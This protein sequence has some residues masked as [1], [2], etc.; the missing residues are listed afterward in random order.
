LEYPGHLSN[1]RSTETT[2]RKINKM[3]IK[4]STKFAIAVMFLFLYKEYSETQF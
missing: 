3:E 1:Q 4:I 2:I